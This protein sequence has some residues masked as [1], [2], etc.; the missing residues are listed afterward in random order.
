MNGVK[1]LLRLQAVK[2]KRL[3]TGILKWTPLDELDAT[4]QASQTGSAGP[5]GPPDDDRFARKGAAGT[6]RHSEGG[7]RDALRRQLY[8]APRGRR[9]FFA[10][11]GGKWVAVA[12]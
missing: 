3:S 11:I 8:V 7:L 6:F 5:G 9:L 2:E 12:A 10:R 1:K 4:V